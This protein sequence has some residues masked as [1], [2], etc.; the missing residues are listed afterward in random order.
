MPVV[1]HWETALRILE[2]APSTKTFKM[3]SACRF[4]TGGMGVSNDAAIMTDVQGE[5]QQVIRITQGLGAIK[6][7]MAMEEVRQCL[8]NPDEVEI[9]DENESVIMWA[10]TNHKL[11][12]LFQTFHCEPASSEELRR[13]TQLTTRH[14]DALLWETKIIGRSENDVLGLFRA[15]GYDG[16]VREEE[17]VGSLTYTSYRLNSS[18]VSLDFR[19]GLL[20]FILWGSVKTQ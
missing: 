14:P 18:R 4:G 3:P 16:F 1:V 13:V 9:L 17:P 12:V 15:Q 10:Y 6:F 20:R 2:A 5:F 11:Q 19:D 7:G 8:G